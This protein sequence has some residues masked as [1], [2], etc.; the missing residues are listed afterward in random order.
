MRIRAAVTRAAD[1]PPEIETLELDEPQPDEVVVRIAASGVC[2]TDLL[3]PH[4]VSLPAVFGHEG[5][6]V[7]ERVGSAVRKVRAGD[8]VVMT[9]GSCGAC[10]QCAVDSPAYCEH[11]HD[12]QFAGRRRDGSK[13]LRAGAEAISGAFFSQSSFATYALGT[14]RS[15]VPIPAAMPFEMAAPLGCGIQTGAGTVLNILRLRAGE[16]LAVFGVGAVGL[17]AVM[18]ARIAEAALIIAV[19]VVPERLSLARELGATHVIDARSGDVVAAIRD[20]SQGGV[21]YSFETAGQTATFTQA[22]ECLRHKGTCALATI[23]ALGK[24]YTQ[25]LLPLLMGGKSLVSVLEGDSDPDRFIPELV[26]HYLAGRLPLE[27]LVVE[28][29][30][31]QIARAFDDAARGRT[32]KPVLRMS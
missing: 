24:P 22:I 31:D 21:R 28:Y 18:A 14:E 8:R 13:T 19:D 12:Y 4:L 17:A 27:R 15:V 16:S 1:Q 32:V 30:F 3:A 2:H 10:P 20:L 23:P 6:G 25:T 26:Q 5:A 11:G 7:V 9:F 29:P